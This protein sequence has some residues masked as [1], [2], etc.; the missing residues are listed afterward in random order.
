MNCMNIS[1]MKP[2]SVFAWL[3]T[4]PMLYG[5]QSPTTYRPNVTPEE[6]AAEEQHQQEMADAIKAQGGMPKQWRQEST[7]SMRKQLTRVADRIEMA[8][9]NMCRALG[10]QEKRDCYYYF[11][12]KSGK[13]I[14]AYADGETIVVMTGMLNFVDSDE[15]LAL[16]LSHEL[17]HNLLGHPDSSRT[18]AITGSILGTIVDIAIASQGLNTQGAFAEVGGNAAV[19]QYSKEF[20]AEADYVGL[21][22]MAN[23]GYDIR[24]APNF[25]RRF[26]VQ[27]PKGIYTSKTHPSNPERF[28][29]LN[30]TVSEIEY[31]QKHRIQLLPDFQ[32]DS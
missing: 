1:F 27:D 17:A 20:E 3:C 25:W 2:L 5:C 9:A 8:G 22:I 30:K 28:V 13:E 10:L 24:Q 7:G 12:Y 11:T 19:L 26:S 18:N 6:M 16:V 15:E 14:N 23:A 29:A 4:I 21:Y 31:K 32:P